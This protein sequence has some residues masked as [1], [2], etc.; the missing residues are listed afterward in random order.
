MGSGTGR[1]TGK[2]ENAS[3]PPLHE[4]VRLLRTMQE[5]D[6][7]NAYLRPR[8]A[9]T[10]ILLDRSGSEPT[11]LMGRRNPALAFMPGKF[12]FPGGRIEPGDRKMNVAGALPETVSDKINLRRG[13]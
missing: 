5:P 8:P 9:A 13:A 4:H 6:T 7:A 2:M 11:V 10:L 12:V 1:R 3:V